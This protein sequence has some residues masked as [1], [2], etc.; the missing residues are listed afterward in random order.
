MTATFPVPDL[1]AHAFLGGSWSLDSLA[2]RAATWLGEKPRWL[3]SLARRI[4]TAFP[5]DAGQPTQ[6]MLATFIA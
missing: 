2:Q 4:M 3:S 1:L 6:E 5:V